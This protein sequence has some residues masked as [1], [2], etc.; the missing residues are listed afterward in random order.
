MLSLYFAHF[1][2]ALFICCMIFVVTLLSYSILLLSVL[3]KYA[4][5]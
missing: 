5:C 4:D 1:Y 3:Y 2:G